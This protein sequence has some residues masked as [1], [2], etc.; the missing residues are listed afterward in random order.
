MLEFLLFGLSFPF[1][2]M[3]ANLHSVLLALDALPMLCNFL[4]KLCPKLDPAPS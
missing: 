2:P 3:P 1:Q 4:D